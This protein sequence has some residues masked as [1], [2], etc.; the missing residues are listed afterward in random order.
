V[1]H[2]EAEPGVLGASKVDSGIN[3]TK[4][5][6]QQLLQSPV[7]CRGPP[8]LLLS[9]TFASPQTEKDMT[10]NGNERKEVVHRSRV[11]LRLNKLRHRGN[12]I[13][14]NHRMSLQA[15]VMRAGPCVAMLG[16]D[17]AVPASGPL[18]RGKV[19]DKA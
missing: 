17:K 16:L 11:H 13:Q 1:G 7:K 3:A 9:H 18:G 8:S 19:L 10:N 12:Q 15:H 4:L 5:M 6:L 2:V 14:S